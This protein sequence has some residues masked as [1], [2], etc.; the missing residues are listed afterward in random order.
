MNRNSGRLQLAPAYI[1]HHHPYRDTSRI[2][3]VLVRDAGRMSLFAR[4]VRGPKARLAS[5][6][7][8]F[9]LLLISA[10][11]RGEAPMLTAAESS[12]NQASVPAASLMAAFYL[13]ELMLK[14]T[15]RH[16]P[17]PNLFDAYHKA[18]EHL[19]AGAAL[20]PALRIFEKRLLD[21]LG[22]CVDLDSD[23]A[24][25]GR[26]DPEAYY[27][28]HPASGLYP[29]AADH[30]GA[31]AGRSLINLSAERLAERLELADARRLLAAA[32]AHCLEGRELA[33]RAVA[34]SIASIGAPP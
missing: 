13:N 11:G 26:V 22:Y 5:V 10:S 1:L 17:Q 29:C 34:R 9:C 23:A 6:L 19:K 33:T 18:I 4:G 30:P 31:L 12:G 24:T 20:Q 14:L 25:G 28:F 27:R 7:Q 21:I 32:L 2:F 8:P 16:D 15:V 3:E